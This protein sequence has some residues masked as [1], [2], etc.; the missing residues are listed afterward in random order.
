MDLEE[1]MKTKRISATLL[2]IVILFS[3]CVSPAFAQED[4]AYEAPV[5]NA[6]KNVYEISKPEQLMYLSGDWKDGAPRDGHYVLTADLDMTNYNGFVPI[7]S[8][9]ERCFIGVFDGQFH[10]IKNLVIDYPKKYVGLFGYLGNE[11]SAAYIKNVALVNC[12]ITGQQ[13]V[14]GI[15]GVAYGTII[16]CY[17]SGK[18]RV[19]DLS[20]AH[21][22][23][24]IAGKVKEGEGPIIGHVENCYTNVQIEAPYDVGGIVGIQDGGGYVGHSFAAGTV[25]IR[26][27]KLISS[28]LSEAILEVRP[29]EVEEEVAEEGEETGEEAKEEAVATAEDEKVFVD[30]EAPATEPAAE[31]QE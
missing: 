11:N 24:G 7:S 5:Y 3:M 28:K 22:G 14:G 31:T 1:K 26:A 25:R 29:I 23:G 21:T 20:N 18:I 27:I 9:K 8:Q 19:D 4:T 17:V 2:V 15:A 12:D 10:V 30:A 16:N 6:A 13:N